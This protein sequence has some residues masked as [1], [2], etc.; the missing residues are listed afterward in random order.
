MSFEKIALRSGDQK[1]P[2]K[3]EDIYD[4]RDF[5][6]RDEFSPRHSSRIPEQVPSQ[7]SDS[8]DDKK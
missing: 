4:P 8:K 7:D 5:Y 1:P 2:L 6:R 3:P